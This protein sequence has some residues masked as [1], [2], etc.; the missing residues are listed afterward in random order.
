MSPLLKISIILVA[1][2][3]AYFIL[4][5][6][7]TDWVLNR[8]MLLAAG[9]G[10]VM[11]FLISDIVRVLHHRGPGYVT[12]GGEDT[13]DYTEKVSDREY[14]RHHLFDDGLLL[15][16]SVLAWVEGARRLAAHDSESK[17]PNQSQPTAGRSD[18]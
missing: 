1:V 11:F 18:E 16:F 3:I 8:F 14:K 17:G 15:V 6:T 2:L 7:R 10:I 4:V 9:L 13:D 12:Y 5:R